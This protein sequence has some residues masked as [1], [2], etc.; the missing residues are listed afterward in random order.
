MFVKF[1]F[2]NHFYQAKL[3]GD[4]VEK[5][6]EVLPEKKPKKKT[7]AK[8]ELP[9]EEPMEEIADDTEKDAEVEIGNEEPLESV[10]L[11]AP[12]NE[13][14]EYIRLHGHTSI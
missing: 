11:S 6:H 14:D 5:E 1:R 8:V 7:P 9:Q 10:G 13:D 3:L 4:S 2:S 12:T